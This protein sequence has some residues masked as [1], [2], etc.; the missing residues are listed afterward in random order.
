[1]LAAEVIPSD[2]RINTLEIY[3]SHSTA[4]Y[5]RPIRANARVSGS[6]SHCISS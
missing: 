3:G 5:Y 1:M 6:T 4:A 2:K